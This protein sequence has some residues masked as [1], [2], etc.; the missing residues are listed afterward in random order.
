MLA[1]RNAAPHFEK[2]ISLF[3][4]RRGGGMVRPDG[5]HLINPLP[6]IRLI[7][8]TAKRRRAFCH[9]TDSLHVV[10]RQGQIMG[11]GFTCD[12]DA[13]SPGG[14]NQ[15]DSTATTHM[16]NVKTTAGGLRA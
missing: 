5:G 16:Y 9:R 10:G 8:A 11:T 14:G 4:V 2:V 13:L 12:V 1:T 7:A 6:Q 3:H 15:F